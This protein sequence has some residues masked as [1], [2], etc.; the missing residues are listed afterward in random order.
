[1]LLK[2][3]AGRNRKEKWP[4]PSVTAQVYAGLNC[5]QNHS[6]SIFTPLASATDYNLSWQTSKKTKSASSM[7]TSTKLEEKASAVAG[8]NQL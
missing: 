8:E 1:M 2:K 5:S 7:K 4:S 3:Q 6:T